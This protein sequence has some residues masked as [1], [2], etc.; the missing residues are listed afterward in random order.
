MRSPRLRF[1]LRL[2]FWYSVNP[3]GVRGRRKRRPY[4]RAGRPRH[5]FCQSSVA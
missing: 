2:L 1:G 5:F 4:V 3:S